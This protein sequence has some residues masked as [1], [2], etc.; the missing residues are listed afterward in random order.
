VQNQKSKMA[1]WHP[2]NT[3]VHRAYI[4]TSRGAWWRGH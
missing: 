2:T 3:T 4:G 1:H